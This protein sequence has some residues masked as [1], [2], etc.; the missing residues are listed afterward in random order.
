MKVFWEV[1][2]DRLRAGWLRIRGAKLGGKVRIGPRCRVTH[3]AGVQ[4][5]ARSWLEADVWL[6]LTRPDARVT[7]GDG[8]VV[9]AGAVVTRAVPPMAV[10]AGNPARVIRMRNEVRRG[11]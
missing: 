4:L 9:G 8:A 2:G 1:A 3:P 10:V 7:I 11:D 6:K 5:G